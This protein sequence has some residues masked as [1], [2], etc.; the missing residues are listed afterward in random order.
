MNATVRGAPAPLT[1]LN[2]ILQKWKIYHS[3]I[4]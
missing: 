1:F 3:L 4:H 2:Q